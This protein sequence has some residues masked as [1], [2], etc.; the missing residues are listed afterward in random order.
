MTAEESIIEDGA[1]STFLESKW[2]QSGFEEEKFEES[3]MIICQMEEN[4][5]NLLLSFNAK[6]DEYEAAGDIHFRSKIQYFLTLNN[7]LTFDNAY[8]P[9]FQYEYIFLHH[10]VILY[11]EE[12]KK[13][14][15]E[16][17]KILNTSGN[18]ETSLQN[19]W[20]ETGKQIY[21]DLLDKL[22]TKHTTFRHETL[23]SLTDTK[24]KA[25]CELF[26]NPK[27]ELFL[28]KQF[29]YENLFKDLGY[30]MHGAQQMIRDFKD[31]TQNTTYY[32]NL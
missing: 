28:K 3:F 8:T 12:Q 13:Q 1:E 21:L 4:Y 26:M 16:N 6:V 23:E 29:R 19:W 20:K 18:D 31:S 22:E 24:L 15:D 2:S 5:Q 9:Q 30:V 27:N 14:I 25:K 10:G 17:F 7:K 32:D 11:V